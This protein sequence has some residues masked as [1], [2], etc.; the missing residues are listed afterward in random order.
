MQAKLRFDQ[1]SKHFPGVQALDRVSFE[2]ER[3]RVHALIGENGAGKSTLLK[4][5][6]GEYQADGG[7]FSIE[8]QAR[9]FSS[10]A[11]AIAAGVAI[12]HQELQYV[13]DLSVTEN[14]MLG[15]M[16]HTAGFV[17]TGEAVRFVKE[18]LRAM[19][20]NLNPQAR[21][22]RLSVAQRQMAEICKAL[23]RN[24]E[25]IALDEPTSSLSYRETQIL[26]GLVR[27]LQ[28]QGKTL[29]Y[30]SH[31]LD[32]IF[33]LCGSC[34]IFR[35][36]RVVTSYASLE[37]VS[38]EVLVR[39]MVGREISDIYSYRSRPLG[40]TRLVVENV[41]GR[42]LPRPVGFSARRGEIVGF[43]G[44]VGAGRSELMRL[45]C[46]ADKRRCGEIVLDG[47]RLTIRS[48]GD[49]IRN[50]IVLCPED[51]KE[52]G[53][54][55]IRSVS[56]NINISCRRHTLRWGLFCDSR[57]E[58]RTADTFIRKLR[59]RTP[60]R[61]QIIR[62]LSGGNQQKTVLARWLAEPKLK[63]VI[64]DEP[65]R[66]IDIGAKNEIYQIIYQLAEQG[67]TVVIV[68]SELPE[69]LGVSDRIVVMRQGQ[70]SG[71]LSRQ[72]ADEEK[73]LHLALPVGEAAA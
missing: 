48:T 52:D 12:I 72:E 46:G 58:A 67:C 25:I 8:G 64:M 65:T 3:G 70:I 49:A 35:D 54:V 37:G 21:L 23:L 36:G 55:G 43:F 41:A 19:G 59:I 10:A 20:V 62:Y 5:L 27:E 56:E 60:N 40:D 22:R 34:T 26:F 66:G 38:R 18:R 29:I 45:I 2:V 73:V 17:R 9:R 30:V 7:D 11:D 32:E 4:I 71:E 33:E 1:I 44:L 28:S 51:R 24:A 42:R 13:P 14:L 15:H 61:R 39:Q 53:I 47:E 16:P 31:R 69:V 57:Q 63:V 68:S 50:G 6:A